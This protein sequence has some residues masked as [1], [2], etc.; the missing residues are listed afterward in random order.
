MYESTGTVNEKMLRGIKKFMM[1]KRQKVVYGL[2][3][4]FCLWMVFSKIVDKDYYQ[5][6]VYLAA[7]VLVLTAMWFVVERS[8][9]VT[10]DRWID[11]GGTPEAMYTTRFD[12]YGVYMKNHTTGQEGLIEYEELADFYVNNDAMFLFTKQG[13]FLVVFPQKAPFS[14]ILEYLEHNVRTSIKW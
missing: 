2:A 4:I 9:R 8:I 12:D 14:E 13:A 7:I 3:I 5:V 6:V 1:K 10:L 11:V